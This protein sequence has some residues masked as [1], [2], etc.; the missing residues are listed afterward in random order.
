M[1]ADWHE[2]ISASIF[3]VAPEFFHIPTKRQKK[4]SQQQD[5][6]YLRY[7]TMSNDVANPELH[8]NCTK[9]FFDMFL[10]LLPHPH[11]CN[12]RTKKNGASSRI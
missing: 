6:S 4:W 8:K 1:S 9:R 2:K 10:S 12:L 11:L 5:F 3:Y 7:G